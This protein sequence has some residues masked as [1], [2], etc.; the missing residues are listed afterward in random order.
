MDSGS[1]CSPDGRPFKHAA[2][3]HAFFLRS[4][5]KSN[6]RDSK[7]SRG[8]SIRARGRNGNVGDEL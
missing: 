4:T 3:E 7:D 2:G 8:L 1:Q 6:S 5:V